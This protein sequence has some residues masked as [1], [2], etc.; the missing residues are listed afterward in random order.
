M[1]IIKLIGINWFICNMIDELKFIPIKF[2]CWKCISFWL[3]LIIMFTINFDF[4]INTLLTNIGI[5]G[6]VSIILN[7]LDNT[8]III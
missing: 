5:S 4:N 2:K 3:S 1:I 8:N 6:I 7:K